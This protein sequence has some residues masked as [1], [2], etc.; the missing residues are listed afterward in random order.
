MTKTNNDMMIKNIHG[1]VRQFASIAYAAIVALLLATGCDNKDYSEDSPF[2]NAVYIDAAKV[3]DVSNFTFN[4]ILETD[5]KKI[6]AVLAFPAGEDVTVGI[7]ADPSQVGAYN[8]RFGTEYPA[9][10]PK[11]Y[12][13]SA[14]QALI[15]KGEVSSKV[16]TIDFSS[17]TELDIDAGYL[18]PVTITSA[19]GGMGI[20][21]GSKTICYVV[22]RS[23]AITTAV[24]LKDNYFEVPGFDAGSSTAGVVNGMTQLTYE[25]II[26]INNFQSEGS[27]LQSEISSIMGIEQYCLLRVGDANFPREQLQFASP[28]YD[29][30]F[31]KADKGKLLEKGEWYHVA[32]TYDI[33]KQT[34]VMYVD[35]IEQSRNEEFAV[36]GWNVIDLGKQERGKH[37]MFKIGHSYGESDDMSRQLDGEI[38]E[39]RV[40]NVA[41]TQQEIW[42]N[43][44]DIDP[45]TPGLCAYWKFNEGKGNIVTDQTGNGNDAVAYNPKVVWPDGIEVPQKNKE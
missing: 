24:N 16:V 27:S 33:E 22:R 15:P 25:A 9:L 34:A 39:V 37:F 1:G 45:K 2:S 42:K 19:S 31:P 14:Q 29:Y 26:R 36:P 5:K 3:K 8:A 7:G 21:G 40:W 43:M 6:S 28:N 10:N 41:R 4:R 17:L 12:K 13:L 20:L 30:K 38:C 11:Y 23:S 32:F 44:Y 18:L 35:G